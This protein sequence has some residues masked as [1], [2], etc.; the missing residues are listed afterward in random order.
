MAFAA[1]SVIDAYQDSELPV[2]TSNAPT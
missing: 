1:I 2:V